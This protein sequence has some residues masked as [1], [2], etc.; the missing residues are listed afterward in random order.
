MGLVGNQSLI[1][2]IFDQ[3]DTEAGG[4][5]LLAD[6]GLQFE[7]P[8]HT[9]RSYEGRRRNVTV[10]LCADRR[11][12]RPLHT[13]AIGGRDAGAREE[14][15]ASGFNVRPARQGSSS[16]RY[17]SAFASF[18]DAL[19]VASQAGDALPVSVRLMARFGAEGHGHSSLPFTPAASVRPGM[20]MFTRMGA[21]PSWRVSSRWNWIGLSMT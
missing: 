2:E 4:K 11:G 12:Q 14:L 8:H 18:G 9:P 21:T 5:R 15:E 17:E 3:L 20:A 10:T 7:H 19:E 13:V 6:L 16:W 1:D